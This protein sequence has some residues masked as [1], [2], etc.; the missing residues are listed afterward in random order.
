MGRSE[1]VF[2][3]PG[4][5]LCVCVFSCGYRS[6]KKKDKEEEEEIRLKNEHHIK[7]HEKN[8]K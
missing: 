8:N 4:A 5:C 3:V 6:L 1:S 7:H 2:L